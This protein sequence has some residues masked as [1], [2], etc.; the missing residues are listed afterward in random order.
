MTICVADYTS[1]PVGLGEHDA[2]AD[3]SN[4]DGRER[5]RQ[6]WDYP[7]RLLRNF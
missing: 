3:E 4:L 1:K 5:G 2:L 6:K 7:K